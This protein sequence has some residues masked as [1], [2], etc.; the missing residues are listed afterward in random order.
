MQMTATTPTARGFKRIGAVLAALGFTA[1]LTVAGGAPANAA[2]ACSFVNVS[3]GGSAPSSI[4]AECQGKVEI[5]WRCSSDLL[6]RTNARTIDF[7]STFNTRT[8]VGCN[9]GYVVYPGAQS[10]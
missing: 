1:A 9:E 7:G 5:T 2:G 10:A 8:F 6:F 3:G 4:V